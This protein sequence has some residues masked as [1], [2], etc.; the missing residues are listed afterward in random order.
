MR[1]IPNAS[2]ILGPQAGSRTEPGNPGDPTQ[3]DTAQPQ[4]GWL[5]ALAQGVGSDY[6]WGQPAWAPGSAGPTVAAGGAGS[7]RPVRCSPGRQVPCA[8]LVT[9]RPATCA[10]LRVL[11]RAEHLRGP[12]SLSSSPDEGRVLP[13]PSLSATQPH[14]DIATIRLPWSSRSVPCLPARHEQTRGPVRSDAG[15]SRS[16]TSRGPRP[17]LTRLLERSAGAAGRLR[18]P[19]PRVRPFQLPRFLRRMAFFFPFLDYW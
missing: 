12:R 8:A 18:A 7:G 11:P 15:T 16:G 9:R 13:P 4:G 6:I 3:G 17:A 19:C 5:C 10:A 2:T 14:P 1:G